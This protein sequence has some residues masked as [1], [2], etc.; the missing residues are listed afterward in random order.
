[1]MPPDITA[2][3]APLLKA[4]ADEVDASRRAIL[5]AEHHFAAVLRGEADAASLTRDFQGIDLAL[6]VLNDLQ[7][8][9][10]R[11][12]EDL[13]RDSAVSLDSA[14]RDLTLERLAALLAAVA[15]A[16]AAVAASQPSIELF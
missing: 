16:P 15:G 10:R 7:G 5:T 11:L 8:V 14:L 13:P 2:P 3:L 9:L 12:A 1:M 4:V 6:Q